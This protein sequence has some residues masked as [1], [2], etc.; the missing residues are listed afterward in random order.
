MAP[1]VSLD[2]DVRDCRP[3]AADGS[4][5]KASNTAAP[6]RR[7]ELSDSNI[8]SRMMVARPRRDASGGNTDRDPYSPRISPGTCAATLRL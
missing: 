7:I 3:Q 4:A 5:A 8:I 1:T 6:P 2:Y